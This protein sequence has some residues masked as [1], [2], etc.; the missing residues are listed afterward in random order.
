MVSEYGGKPA[1]LPAN[2]NQ[3]NDSDSSTTKAA[4]DVSRLL[5]SSDITLNDVIAMHLVDC[6]QCNNATRRQ[7]P[8]A[9]GQKSGHC[10]DY[11]QLQLMQAKHEGSVNNIVA[12]TEFG[13]SAR[14]GGSL[15]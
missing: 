13:D 11:W 14:K 5:G 12:Y 9:L 1:R 15:E 10:D 6:V 8:V 2:G 7:R 4:A 3:S